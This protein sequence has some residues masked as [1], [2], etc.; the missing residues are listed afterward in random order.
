ML[1]QGTKVTLVLINNTRP[2][3]S[4]KS[5]VECQIEFEVTCR[6]E[7]AIIG[8]HPSNRFWRCHTAPGTGDFNAIIVV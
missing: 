2:I 1:P 4:G 8:A 3:Y 5:L 6:T 7:V